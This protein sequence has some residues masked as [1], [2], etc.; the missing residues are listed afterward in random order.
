MNLKKY[1]VAYVIETGPRKYDFKNRTIS[2]E[3]IKNEEDLK[4]LEERIKQLENWERK[5]NNCTRVV[6][7]N[8]P[9]P[10]PI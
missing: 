3:E 6:M 1:F 9:T 2:A 5:P 10:L 4:I 7:I 8:W